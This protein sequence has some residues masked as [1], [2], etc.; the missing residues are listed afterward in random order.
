VFAAFRALPDEVPRILV[1][2][3]VK[4]RGVSF[5]EHPAALRDGDG[6]YRWHAG[7]PDDDAYARARGELL[8]RIA[9]GLEALGA[10]PLEL[11]R[12]GERTPAPTG[13]SLQGEPESGA[14]ERRLKDEAEYVAAA[15]GEEVLALAARH[16]HVVVL[17][18]DLASDCR[19]R[20]VEQ[21]LPERFVENG[22]A[23]QDMVS[24]AAGL[25]RH[26]VLPIVSSFA[27]FLASRANEQI[28]NQASER[29]R[30]VYALH[31]AGL[32]PAGPGKSHQSLRDVSLLGALPDV[33]VVQPANGAEA[34]ALARWA[35]ED[36][37]E[38]VAIRLAIGPSPR[39]LP[40]DG[41]PTPGR[42][43]TIRAGDDALLVA[44]G[45][46]MLAEAL[47]AAEL[48]ADRGVELAVVAMPWLNR[49]DAEWAAALV[50]PYAEVHVLEDHAPVGALGDAV[51]RALQP[52]GVLDGRPL[53]VVG[54]EGWPACGTPS[55]AL[56]HHGLD[57]R[58]LAARIGAAVTARS[59]G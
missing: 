16:P 10:G 6:L 8:D 29:S 44:Y 33:L 9:R 14:G 48:L 27:S 7:A 28:Y 13:E 50:E 24:M 4:G 35:V 11:E 30:V 34:R 59:A 20:A 18:A 19:I 54:V 41:T 3:T 31:Y 40:L 2:D 17:D 38:S 42:G 57:A 58:S 55:E 39:S 12:D 21:E 32:V 22:I 23:E 25:A 46:V 53:H 52:A 56:A 26:G 43:T 36:A 37:D 5:M 45:P 51:L 47:G 49:V 15:F 1:A